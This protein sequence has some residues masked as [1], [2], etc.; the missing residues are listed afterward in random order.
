VCHDP[1]VYRKGNL[2]ESPETET[3]A[4]SVVFAFFLLYYIKSDYIFCF[5]GITFFS[6]ARNLQSG[7]HDLESSP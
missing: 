7:I 2:C 1:I 6:H 3:G 5:D 4:D